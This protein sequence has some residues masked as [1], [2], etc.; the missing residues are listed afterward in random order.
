MSKKPQDTAPEEGQTPSS[1]AEQFGK[2]KPQ[3]RCAQHK[4]LFD[5]PGEFQQHL[6]AEHYPPPPSGTAPAPR[7]G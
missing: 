7:R 3:W 2:P 1:E 5:S 4:L 6:E